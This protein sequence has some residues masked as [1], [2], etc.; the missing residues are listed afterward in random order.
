MFQY[1]LGLKSCILN[2]HS[3]S[4]SGCKLPWVLSCI[5]NKLF[6]NIARLLVLRK[7]TICAK[8]LNFIRCHFKHVFPD[9]AISSSDTSIS[10]IA[11]RVISCHAFVLSH[12]DLLRSS[13]VGLKFVH[14]VEV[15]ALGYRRLLSLSQ[16]LGLLASPEFDVLEPCGFP[17]NP[18]DTKEDMLSVQMKT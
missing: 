6:R 1:S 14:G 8:L 5:L 9:L 13:C 2:E 3:P 4:K 7:D 18:E 15:K 10:A 16:L 17:V 12:L 11:C